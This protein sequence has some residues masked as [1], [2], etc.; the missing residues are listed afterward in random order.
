MHRRPLV[1]DNQRPFELAH[2]FGVD[3]EVGLKRE[4]DVNAGRDVDERAARPDGRIESRELVV[5]GRNDRSKV[6]PQQVA[7]FP[8]RRIGVGEDD[9]LLTKFFLERPVDDFAFELSLDAGE[10]LPFGFGDSQLVERLLDF[11]RD[12]VPAMPLLLGRFEVVINVLEIDV[13][14]A[15]PLRHRLRFEDFQGFQAKLAHPIGLA[16]HLGNLFDD[17]PVE[18][19]ASSKDGLRF[20]VEIVLVDFADR[21]GVLVARYFGSHRRL[22]PCRVPCPVRASSLPISCDTDHQAPASTCCMARFSASASGY[23]SRIRP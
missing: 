13:D 12:F 9:S 3:A 10:E 7:V 8:D 5:A 16:L 4:V 23:F 15:A 1:D 21:A 14:L 22:L 2:P 19:L 18:S 17:F 6:L 20:G 11:L